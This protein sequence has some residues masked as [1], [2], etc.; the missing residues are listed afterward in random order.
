MANVIIKSDERREAERYVASQFHLGSSMSAEE[1]DA[2]ET[3]NARAD[4]AREI[5]HRNEGRIVR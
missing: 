1:R 5:A 4:E 2:V 3:I